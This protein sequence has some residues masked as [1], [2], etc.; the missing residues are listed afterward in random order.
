MGWDC[1]C[2]TV[3]CPIVSALD[4]R[5]VAVYHVRNSFFLVIE[6]SFMMGALKQLDCCPTLKRNRISAKLSFTEGKEVDKEWNR[7]NGV[8]DSTSQA[9]YSS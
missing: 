3:N 8:V 1:S 2:S 7:M 6:Y 4:S 5:K 9:G